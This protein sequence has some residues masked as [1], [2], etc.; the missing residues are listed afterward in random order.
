MG[1]KPYPLMTLAEIREILHRRAAGEQ[2]LLDGIEEIDGASIYYHTHSY[3]LRGKYRHDRYPN[4]FATWVADQ[5]RDRVLSE[6]LSMVDPSTF[7]DVEGLRAGLITI[8]E[9]HLDTIGFSPRAL[10]GE[11]FEFVRAHIVVLPTGVEVGSRAELKAAL[12]SAPP[13]TLFYH[14]FEDAFGRGR[15]TGS[16]V[17]WVAE[18][19]G[20]APLAAA[21]AA[22]NPYCLHLE[23]LRTRILRALDEGGGR[24]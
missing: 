20:D 13:E 8:I 9:Q 19:L 23:Q 16:L 2:D 11:P 14:F 6:R 17:E 18:D 21:L 15:R 10:F 7:A 4:D 3:Y 22:V 5:V 12:A 24:T 1:R